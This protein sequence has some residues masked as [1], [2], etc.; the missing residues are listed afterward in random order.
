MSTPKRS[1][2]KSIT[3]AVSSFILSTIVTW[4]I[5]GRL[6]MALGITIA[7]HIVAFVWYYG[8]E[9]IWDAIRWGKT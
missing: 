2:S 1:L 6:D 9:R 4:I 3:W 8:H 7:D 5:T